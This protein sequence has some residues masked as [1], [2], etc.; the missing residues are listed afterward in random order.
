VGAIAAAPL[1]PEQWIDRM[2][3]IQNYEEDSSAMGRIEAWT[4]A[5][6][7][8]LD[9]PI[10]GGGFL[11]NRDRDLFFS[12]VPDAAE[13]RAFHSVL[14]EVLGEHGFV[15]LAIYLALLFAA[16]ANVSSVI[17]AARKREDL[18]WASDLVRMMRV[19]LV[20]FAVCGLFLNLAFFDLYYH[21]IALIFCTKLLV[22]QAVAPARTPALAHVPAGNAQAPAR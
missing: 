19:S 2:E 7:L 21:V 12:Y 13:E 15:G 5:W 14:F 4:F 16:L 1:V 6:R 11:V 9:R 10:T 20:G 22:E 8:A 3:S 18:R 17:R